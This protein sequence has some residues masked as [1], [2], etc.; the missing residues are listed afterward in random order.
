MF[1]LQQ[2]FRSSRQGLNRKPYAR[3][4]SFGEQ[5]LMFDPSIKNIISVRKT[6]KKD[7]KFDS[8]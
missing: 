2:R 7:F 1:Y 6:K 3:K 8:S 4:G 5:V